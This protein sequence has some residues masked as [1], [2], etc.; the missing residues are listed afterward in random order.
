[1]RNNIKFGISA[2]FVSMLIL[3]IA[4][5]PAM[6]SSSQLNPEQTFEYRYDIY[7]TQEEL[8]VLHATYNITEN[9]VKFA[10]NELPNFLEGTILFS[11]KRVI[12]SNDRKPPENFKDGV[13]YDIVITT[14]EMHAIINDAKNKYIEKYSVDPSNPKMDVVNGYMIPKDEAKRLAE[15]GEL[16]IEDDIS[17]IESKNPSIYASTLAKSHVPRNPSQINGDIYAHIFVAKDSNHAP[18]ES[19]YQDTTDALKRFE[20]F[21]VTVTRFWYYNYWD[22]SD[23][24]PTEEASALLA[25][26]EQDTTWVIYDKNDIVVGWVDSMDHNG[27]AWRP[28]AFSVCAVKAI[29]FD[30]P[31]DSIVQHEVSHN[32]D[33]EDQNSIFHPECIMNYLDAY[34]GTN[35]WCTSCG[36]TVDYGINN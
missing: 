27:I 14:E 2:L 12:V 25:D 24:T 9:D 21:G 18:T 33:A 13:D 20:N 26:L 11:D 3:S 31:H 17:L 34:D 28:G 22:A 19:Y 16:S 7:Y 8:Q 6:S 1:M 4:V 32:F 30:W 10:R 5:A 29:G 15:S 23:V 36:N 35:I